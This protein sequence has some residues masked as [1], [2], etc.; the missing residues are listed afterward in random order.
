[1]KT[2]AYQKWYD[3]KSLVRTARQTPRA[4]APAEPTYRPG[5]ILAQAEGDKSKG[6]PSNG[7]SETISGDFEIPYAQNEDGTE[8]SILATCKLTISVEDWGTGS[9]DGEQLIDCTTNKEAPDN[10]GGHATWG[11]SASKTCASGAHSYG[12]TAQNITMDDPNQNKFVCTYSFEAVCLEAGGKKPKEPC[13]C[14]ENTCSPDGGAPPP[15]QGRAR[16]ALPSP[17]FSASSAGSTVEAGIDENG[18]LWSCSA[19]NLRGLG[20]QLPGWLELTAE[21]LTASLS[22]PS[23]LAFRHPLA[24]QLTIPEGGLVAGAKLELRLGSRVIAFRCYEDGSIRP[25][26]VDTAGLGRATLSVGSAPR[27]RWQNA[28]GE[29]WEFSGATGELLSYADKNGI[30][31]SDVSNYLQIVRDRDGALRQIWSY[32]DGLVNIE[33]IVLGGYT[34][35]LYTANQIAGRDETTGLYT[36]KEGATSFKRFVTAFSAATFTIT[37]RTPERE[38]LVRTWAESANGGW[39]LTTGVG[40]E[41]VTQTQER[42]ELEAGTSDGMLGVWQLITSYAKGGVVAARTC[43]IYQ[44]TPVGNLCLTRVEGYGSDTELTTTFEYDGAG[45]LVVETSPTG[46]KKSFVYDDSGRVI[47]TSEPWRSG[48]N[49]LIEDTVY[50]HSTED[51]YDTDPSSVTVKLSPSGGEGTT[52][53]LRTDKYTYA[54][55]EGVKRVE[56]RSTALGSSETQL[57]ILETWLDTGSNPYARGRTRMEQGLD[58]VQTWYDYAATSA[59]GALYCQ[60][61]ETR[62]NGQTVAGQS[63]RQVRFI[64]SEG[65]T[66][67][68]ESWLMDS[69]GTWRMTAAAD[70]EFDVQ[71]R[72]SNRTRMNGRITTRALMCTGEPLWEIDEDGVRTDYAYDSARRLVEI[73]RSEVSHGDAVVTPETITSYARDAVGHITHERTDTGAMTATTSTTYDLAGRVTMQ[74]DVLGRTTATAYSSDGLTTTLT[75]PSGATLVTVRHP[76]GSLAREHGTG[77]RDVRHAYDLGGGGTRQT[78]CLGDT[79]TILSQEIQDGF[80]SRLTRTTPTTEGYVYDRSVYDARG[81]LIR[82]QRDTGSS[83]GAVR[84]APTLMEYDDFGN[85][86][87]ETLQ[88]ADEPTPVNSDITTY[89]YAVEN[90][91][92]GVYRTT[93]VTR[94]NGNGGTYTEHT[95]ELVSEHA[96]LERKTVLTDPRGN[97]TTHWVEYGAGPVRVRKTSLPTSTMTAEETIVDGFTIAQSDETGVS[98]SRSRTYTETGLQLMETDGRGNTTTTTTDLAGRTVS[99]IDAAGNATTTVYDAYF[100]LPALVTDALG[101]T[102]CSR[103]DLRGRKTAEWGTG[104]QPALFAYD[105]ADRLTALTTFRVTEGDIAEDPA[106][107]TDGDATTWAYHDATGLVTQKTYADGS[108]VVQSWDA[109]NRPATVTNARG[110][111]TTYAYETARGLLTGVSFSDST[112]A[113]SYGWNSVGKLVSVTDA[114]GTRALSYND[115]GE[116]S[117]DALEADGKTHAIEEQKDAFGRGSG[118]T[119]TKDDAVQQTTGITYDETGRIAAASFQ[120]GGEPKSFAYG[121]LEGTRLL[122]S[123]AHPNNITITTAYEATRDLPVSMNATRGTTDVVLRGYTYDA[124]ARPS[125]RSLARQAATR[126]DAFAYNTRSELT[127]AELGTDSYDYAYDNIGN[128]KTADEAAV[129]RAYTSNNLNQ[130]SSITKAE[131]APFVPSFDARRQSNQNQDLHGHLDGGLRRRKP[132]GAFRKGS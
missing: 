28:N 56:K 92:E 121:Y 107:R 27:F 33:N 64:N 87:Q 22:M 102:A 80:G 5:Q 53:V 118:Y 62:V 110:L 36:L 12:M 122:Q 51:H 60:T 117:G 35:A 37:E 86:T 58:G 131:E 26:G 30:V 74:T 114:S 45:N 99:V 2:P 125:A 128:R 95:A 97:V 17:A 73:I 49:H 79:T 129:S 41:A 101:H 105:E 52:V 63:T 88:L 3:P 39:S 14:E 76:D 103:Y 104:I 93:T 42:S 32:W 25:I 67:R 90:R 126:Q 65:A 9:I 71:N 7:E 18:L 82:S 120:H 94:C 66:V 48:E 84:M 1:M 11:G 89:A 81:L 61:A 21:E 16:A 109:F 127:G 78:T 112:P 43:D 77:R 20:A 75:T 59:H 34:I 10:L 40:E 47:R 24:A 113:R 38:D 96:S 55:A 57:S 4:N 100:D 83:S 23:A 68:E 44:T 8:E 106:G 108:Q 50:A 6:P 70:Y 31:V 85:L 15:P 111:T 69:E 54:I 46:Q 91:A 124:L 116:A 130:Y 119:Y 132:P 123:L 72:W 13:G 29:A 115:Y 19:A 98:V